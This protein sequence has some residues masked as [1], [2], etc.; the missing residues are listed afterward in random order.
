MSTDV[1]GYYPRQWK[2]GSEGRRRKFQ[3]SV[4][5][6]VLLPRYLNDTCLLTGSAK[7]RDDS[8]MALAELPLL[9]AQSTD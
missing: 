1:M 7:L 5:V 4:R 6:F 8:L 2:E 3:T 9:N